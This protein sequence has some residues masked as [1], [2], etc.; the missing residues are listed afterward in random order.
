MAKKK[1]KTPMLVGGIAGG[2][3]LLCLCGGGIFGLVVMMGDD[4]GSVG[5][6]GGSPASSIR[7][8]PDGG[9]DTWDTVVKGLMTGSYD[10][11]YTGWIDTQS[12]VSAIDCDTWKALD[13][14][15]KS[16]WGQGILTIYGFEP[17]LLWVGSAVGFDESVR[18]AA[19]T[20]GNACINGGGGTAVV[21]PT[22]GADG[23]GSLIRVIPDG[24][25]SEWDM[26]VKGIMVAS[27]D[28]N[29]SGWIDT[30]DEVSGVS[31][32]SWKAL[33]DGVKQKY[34]PGLRSI[35]GFESGMIWLGGE[36]GFSESVRTQADSA[37]AGCI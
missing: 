30:A 16:T 3:L 12:E 29:G 23:V 32:D 9:S 10:T 13:D 36:V 2:C 21:A 11:N 19:F 18:A 15:V 6:I 22:G 31:C 20:A 5:S 24:G 14:G 28:K 26:T 8:T 33:D 34:S 4:S 17:D 25:S 35:Y 7:A 27:Y 1:S 37:L